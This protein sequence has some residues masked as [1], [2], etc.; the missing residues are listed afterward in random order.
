MSKKVKIKNVETSI[1]KD[2]KGAKATYADLM[3]T[4][5]AQPQQEG[6]PL[7]EMYEDFKIIDVLKKS[8]ENIEF[9]QE[10]F[11]RVF[12]RLENYKFYPKHEEVIEFYKALLDLK[13]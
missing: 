1:P 13:K 8:E 10:Q 5:F 7:I 11:D 6:Q 2:E 9:T 3:T 4:V 12:P